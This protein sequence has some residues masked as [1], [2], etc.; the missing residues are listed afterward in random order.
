[1]TLTDHQL[2]A[3][4]QVG[5]WIDA[6]G[7]ARA[8]VRAAYRLTATESGFAPEVLQAGEQALLA[9]GL[10][11]LERDRLTPTAALGPFVQIHD[12][13]AARTALKIAI[14]ASEDDLRAEFGA[15]GEDYVFE[16]VRAE[17]R[18]LSRPDLAERCVRVSLVSDAFGYD[19]AAPRLDGSWRR[20]EVKSQAG[21]AATT[22]RFFLTRHEYETGLAAPGEWALVV[23]ARPTDVFEVLGWCRAQTL[24]TYL[25][26]D[27]GGRWSEAVVE[28][29]L[30]ALRAGIPSSV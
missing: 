13:A 15:E 24:A 17:L 28:L 20:L 4:V 5:R 16:A 11:R 6:R 3:A 21:R 23:C 22:A 27:Q 25:P 18:A 12:D 26:S 10:L 14:R 1:M 8:D 7:N 30:S 19:V 9:A 2:A 29:P